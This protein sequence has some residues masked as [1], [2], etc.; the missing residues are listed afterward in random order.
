MLLA[1]LCKSFDFFSC[2][3]FPCR[4]IGVANKKDFCFF[5]KLR[6]KVFRLLPGL[7]YCGS[8]PI[9]RHCISYSPKV[10]QGRRTISPFSTTHST[11]SLTISVEPL[12][13]IIFCGATPSPT[14]FAAASRN[15]GYLLSGYS[16]KFFKS[17]F[18]NLI[19]VQSAFRMLKR[20][21]QR[22]KVCTE[23]KN[24]AFRNP[25]SLRRFLN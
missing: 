8:A 12:P 5:Q 14:N 21:S 4:V 1:A 23:V 20:V 11:T 13:G 15:S 22:I 7:G 24:F 25:V 10:G 17:L 19:K 3:E 18:K 16:D 6:Q 9:I 2:T